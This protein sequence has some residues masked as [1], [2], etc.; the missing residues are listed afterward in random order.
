MT[1]QEQENEGVICVRWGTVGGRRRPLLWQRP[2]GHPV[3]P[4]AARLIA[5]AQIGQPPRGDCEEP[6]ANMPPATLTHGWTAP[7]KPATL[8]R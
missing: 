8:G 3:L 5:A 7:S 2:A 4:A 6:G 1:A